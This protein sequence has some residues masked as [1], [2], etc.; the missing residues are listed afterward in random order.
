MLSTSAYHCQAGGEFGRSR[1]H[2]S[3]FRS[4]AA[5][6]STA[7]NELKMPASALQAR[8]SIPVGKRA[9]ESIVTTRSNTAASP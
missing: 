9:I 6:E 5:R 8:Q 7:M 1:N 2:R 3:M 4:A